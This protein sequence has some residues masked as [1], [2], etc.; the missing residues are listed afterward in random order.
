M[1]KVNWSK[2]QTDIEASV[3]AVLGNAF[4]SVSSAARPQ[5]VAMVAIG[6]DIETQ[7][8]KG[9]LKEDEYTSL[10][11]MQKNALEGILSG[12]RGIGA[13][14]AEQA[15]DAAWKVVAAALLKSAGIPFA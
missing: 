9:Q 12:Y 11:S 10:R 3:K 7:Y 4:G 13:L 5:I 14:T 15:A 8:E 2:V 1:P 6:R